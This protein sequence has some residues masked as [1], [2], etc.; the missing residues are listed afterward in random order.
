[1][2]V[3]SLPAESALDRR[4]YPEALVLSTWWA[5]DGWPHRAYRWPGDATR[6]PRGSL[7][8]QSGRIDFIEK[9][10]E[11]CEH[12]HRQGWAV[13]GFDWRGQGGSGRLL[14]GQ[15]ADHRDSF[16]PLIDDLEAF[17]AE[18]RAR[19]PGPHVLVGHSMG[20]H[21]AFRLVAERG[22]ALDASVLVAPM[23]R[24]NT[25]A[26][27]LAVA[28]TV[29]RAAL[30]LGRRRRPAWAERR[31]DTRRQTRLTADRARY[32][33]SQWWKAQAP[34]L[35]G[36]AP[37]WG[38]L[39]AAFEAGD[40][41]ERLPLDRV[42]TPMLLLAAGRDTLVDDGMIARVS[43]RLPDGEMRVFA[44]AAHELLREAD[45]HRVAALASIDDF[46]ARRVPVR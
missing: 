27:P 20:G 25:G 2:P 34:E 26:V 5:P 10:F 42:R 14:P 35:A 29:A 28:R 46:L 37:S 45:E 36:G 32:D 9:Y 21:V 19:A 43:H 11:A 3:A 18:W 33:D 6:R 23:L 13:E 8:F 38:W 40:L 39:A 30:L 22:V 31:D 1:M 7:L 12:W 17:V 16:D 15:S 4:R 44:G 41:I 24:V